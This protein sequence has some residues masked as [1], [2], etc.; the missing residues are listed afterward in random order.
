MK[1]NLKD[2]DRKVFIK[3]IPQLT[4]GEGFDNSF[5]RSAQLVLNSLG[6]E[7]SY[8]FLMGISGAAFRL[9]FHPDFCPSSADSTVGFDVS[10]VLFPSLGYQIAV[11]K[12]DGKSF[13]DIRSL[14]QKITE[15]INRGIPMIAINLK[16][17]PEWGIIT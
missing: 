13:K 17:C 9:H 1:S 7:Y 16:V 14:Y 12:I 11:S 3:D 2:T 10:S 5:I 6:E 8:K 4:W 15:Q